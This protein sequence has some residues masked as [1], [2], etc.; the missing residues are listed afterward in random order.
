MKQKYTSGTDQQGLMSPPRE[1]PLQYAGFFGSWD[2]PHYRFF[3]L[4]IRVSMAGIFLGLLYIN[5]L[6]IHEGQL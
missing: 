1:I 5:A 4:F 3:M 2:S 6:V